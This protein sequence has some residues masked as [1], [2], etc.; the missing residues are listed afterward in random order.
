[1]EKRDYDLLNSK[2]QQYQEQTCDNFSDVN[3]DI[4]D[5][6]GHL[7]MI[8]DMLTKLLNNSPIEA[9]HTGGPGTVQKPNYELI[10]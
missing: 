9:K 3:D 5:I 10:C 2:L 7:L 4:D 1:M 6:R 8:E